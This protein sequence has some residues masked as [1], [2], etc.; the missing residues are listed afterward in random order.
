MAWMA[1]YGKRSAFTVDLIA[2]DAV[3]TYHGD[4]VP[5]FGF[6][7]TGT[8]PIPPKVSEFVGMGMELGPANDEVFNTKESKS[9]LGAVGL[10]TG[11]LIDRSAYYEHAIMLALTP[12]FR[13]DVYP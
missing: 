6:G 13:P 12:W 4:R 10:L 11:G 3:K 7:K 5:K 2:S 9:G 8:F 1:I